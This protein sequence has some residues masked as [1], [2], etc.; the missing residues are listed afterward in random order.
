MSSLE[1]F[2]VS[3]PGFSDLVADELKALGIRRVAEVPGGVT[4]RGSWRDIY[5]A[6]LH[7]RVGSRVLVRVA[8]FPA[9]SFKELQKGL[10]ALDLTPWLRPGTTANIKITTKKTTLFHSGKIAEIF[11]EATGIPE[12][13]G[14]QLH[15]RIAKEKATL[16]I[17]TSGAHLHKRGYRA[18]AGKAPLRENLA[19]ALLI[20]AGY[21]GSLPLLDP[22]C[23]SGT[24][25]IEAALI[26]LN[27]APGLKRK[28]A[29]E[30]FPSFKGDIWKTELK[31][32]VAGEVK[33]LAES[34]VGNDIDP[35]A[36]KLSE[37]AAKSAG[38]DKFIDFSTLD[39]A[40]LLPRE[41]SGLLIANPPYGIR[42]GKKRAVYGMIKN[43]LKKPLSGWRFGVISPEAN[44][45]AGNAL[46]VNAL[47]GFLNGGLELT[48]TTGE[49]L[50]ESRLDS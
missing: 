11:R 34:I 46:K 14:S 3:P 47:F 18:L 9:R 6:N 50:E 40:L 17:D 19:A 15:L 43:L 26:A 10:K 36:I 28:F 33:V 13:E 48:F 32:A 25:P 30:M 44:G 21:D 49:S 20:R 23:G 42:I 27:R 38:V 1:G 8:R 22:C 12:G 39:M 31:K 7:S 2:A 41:K 4:F 16:S 35:E 37:V 45:F 24:L 5:R 29:F